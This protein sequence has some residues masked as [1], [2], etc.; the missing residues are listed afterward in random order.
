MVEREGPYMCNW[1]NAWLGDGYYFWEGF[2]SNAHWWGQLRGYPR[3]YIICEAQYDYS[4]LT[5]FDLVGNPDHIM[6][7]SEIRDILMKK[8][9][10]KSDDITV[11]RLIQLMQKQGRFNFEAIRADGRKTRNVSSKLNKK[12][13]FEL[14][15][16]SYLEGNPTIQ[17]CFIE[18]TSMNLRDYKVIYP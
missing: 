10:I 9:G 8:K 12:I 16:P 18:K 13:K 7:I 2:E 14:N 6:Q 1:E 3:G 11:A 15:K 4:D 5:L 17:I